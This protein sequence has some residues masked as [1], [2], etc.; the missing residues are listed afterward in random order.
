MWKWCYTNIKT[1]KK[2]LKR[3]QSRRLTSL[4]VCLLHL[5]EGK[6]GLDLPARLLPFVFVGVSLTFSW[7]KLKKKKKIDK[8]GCAMGIKICASA[9]S[10]CIYYSFY[11]KEMNH[12]KINGSLYLSFCILNLAHLLTNLHYTRHYYSNPINQ[13]R[14]HF[15]FSSSKISNG[16]LQPR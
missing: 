6:F 15:S 5:L 10:I 9:D 11:V 3:N 1:R 7:K 16:I 8:M 14:W 13:R 12:L 4:E 2:L